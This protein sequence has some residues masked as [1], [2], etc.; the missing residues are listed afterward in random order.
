LLL[1]W[2]GYYKIVPPRY[3]YVSPEWDP[4][5]RACVSGFGRRTQL[6]YMTIVIT[7]WH[8][9]NSAC[10]LFLCNNSRLAFQINIFDLIWYDSLLC[11]MADWG[12][13]GSEDARYKSI[14]WCYLQAL[15][16]PPRFLHFLGFRG[17]LRAS[18]T[19][20]VPGHFT[21]AVRGSIL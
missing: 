5:I 18:K 20:G 3:A 8:P 19:I 13:T 21:P 6:L 2:N 7:M 10:I 1:Q 4:L 14:Q 15:R 16:A 17:A 9:L 12:R 11:Q